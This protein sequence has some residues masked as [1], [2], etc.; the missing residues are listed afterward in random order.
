[1]VHCTKCGAELKEGAVFCHSCGAS[2]TTKTE[3][4]FG[5]RSRKERDE[6]FGSSGEACFGPPGSGVGMWGAISGGI[7]IIGIGLL[8]FFDW[9]WPGILFLIGLMMIVGGIV[10]LSRR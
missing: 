9:F 4:V 6:C 3:P 2:V 1:M 10:A 8:W 7:F 5:R